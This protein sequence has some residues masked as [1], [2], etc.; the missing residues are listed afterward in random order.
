M[1]YMGKMLLQEGK[2][3]EGTEMGGDELVMGEGW[4][5]MD[6]QKNLELRPRRGKRSFW[7]DGKFRAAE[8]P[9]R[10]PP[11]E[12]QAPKLQASLLAK[13]RSATTCEC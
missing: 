8:P 13:Q 1:G 5:F 6:G 4:C 2:Q 11:S 12:L 3:Q 7:R 9:P 10:F